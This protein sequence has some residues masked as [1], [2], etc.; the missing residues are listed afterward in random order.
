MQKWEYMTL[1]FTLGVWYVN[2]QKRPELRRPT[3]ELLNQFG[4]EGWEMVGFTSEDA[5]HYHK[6][7]FKRAS[8]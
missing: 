7:I 1:E 4:Q 6:Y 8:P 5:A 2:G 3:I